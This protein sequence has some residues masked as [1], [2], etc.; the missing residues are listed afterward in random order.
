MSKLLEELTRFIVENGA[1]TETSVKKLSQEDQAALVKIASLVVDGWRNA[2]PMD[3]P[4]LQAF[5]VSAFVYGHNWV[6]EHWVLW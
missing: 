3:D 2:G 4:A 6:K 5:W 1:L